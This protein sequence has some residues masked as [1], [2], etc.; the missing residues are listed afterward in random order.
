[1]RAGQWVVSAM[2]LGVIALVI[3]ALFSPPLQEA[4]LP[5]A[6]GVAATPVAWQP[7]PVASYVPGKLKLSEGHWQGMDAMP[8]SVELKTKLKLPMNLEGVLLGETTLAS[9]RAGLLAGDVLVAVE[10]NPVNT[11]EGLQQ[12]SKQVAQRQSVRLRVYRQ[13]RWFDHVMRVPDGV[14][15]F[16][17]MESAP[18][19]KAGDLRPHA[20]RGPC[21][22]CHAI[23]DTGHITPDPDGIILPAP[24]IRAGAVRPHSDRGPCQACH[25]VTN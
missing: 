4:V 13:G 23:G 5:V 11:L 6:Q 10:G 16:A 14:L 1:M 8:L 7:P 3:G 9:A 25:R 19:I 12:A 2:I 20:Y 22:D 15:G 21:T 17:Q 24:V 18:M